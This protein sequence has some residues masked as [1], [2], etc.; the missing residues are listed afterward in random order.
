MPQQAAGGGRMAWSRRQVA[1]LVH[2]RSQAAGSGHVRQRARV[3]DVRSGRAAVRWRNVFAVFVMGKVFSSRTEKEKASGS[4]SSVTYAGPCTCVIVAVTPA[5]LTCTGGQVFEE[6]GKGD[7]AGAR[8]G[9][10]GAAAI[11][12]LVEGREAAQGG[13]G[14]V[15][16]ERH[17]AEATVG[18]VSPCHGD[19]Q[20]R[21]TCCPLQATRARVARPCAHFP[22]S[23]VRH[24]SSACRMLL[25]T[26]AGCPP[27]TLPKTRFPRHIVR[28]EWEWD[29]LSSTD[30]LPNP[31]SLVCDNGT[32][33]NGIRTS[34]GFDGRLCRVISAEIALTPQLARR[35]PF[36]GAYNDLGLDAPLTTASSQLEVGCDDQSSLVRMRGPVRHGADVP[37]GIPGLCAR[38]ACQ[39]CGRGTARTGKAA[40]GA[41]VVAVLRAYADGR[42]VASGMQCVHGGGLAILAR[43]RARAAA[44]LLGAA[45]PTPPRWHMCRGHAGAEPLSLRYASVLAL[46]HHDSVSLFPRVLAGP[47]A[48]AGGVISAHGAHGADVLQGVNRF[49]LRVTVRRGGRAIVCAGRP[50]CMPPARLLFF[51]RMPH[52][53]PDCASY[54]PV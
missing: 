23:A 22:R 25:A 49:M 29:S 36:A 53:A 14:E 37:P 34:D 16:L 52:P 26:S 7:S 45:A 46:P 20:A 31:I 33:G 44:P 51:V 12:P 8:R 32:R 50:L 2:R 28:E 43:L 17:L 42:A 24:T 39:W 10:A 1:G 15:D 30:L 11:G 3:G 9:T 38:C 4:P 19:T 21:K 48:G 35:G 40:V 54:M 13:K 27:C 47:C 18:V 6:G 41:G 5:W